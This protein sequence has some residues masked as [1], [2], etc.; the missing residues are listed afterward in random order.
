MKS[1]K[2]IKKIMGYIGCLLVG[3]AVVVTVKSA[4]DNGK[5]A[6][7]YKENHIYG[8]LNAEKQVIYITGEYHGEKVKATANL[9][10]AKL[11]M[12]ATSGLYEGKIGDKA[13]NFSF[14]VDDTEDGTEIA[15]G[16]IYYRPV[17]DEEFIEQFFPTVDLTD[18]ATRDNAYSIHYLMLN[19]NG[20][21]KWTYFYDTK[22]YG[23]TLAESFPAI[24]AVLTKDDLKQELTVRAYR[25]LNNAEDSIKKF[26]ENVLVVEIT[27]E[28]ILLQF[29]FP[30]NTRQ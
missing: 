25:E 29:T 14:S 21:D 28:D 5:E 4:M 23:E 15:D 17:Y 18:E 26:K 16:L 2:V 19:I 1:N 30:D 8:R 13:V 3:F 10:N 20:T 6:R 9:S 12:F 24:R 11:D 22:I 27:G 7:A